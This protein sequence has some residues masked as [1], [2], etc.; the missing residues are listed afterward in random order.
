MVKE[1][2]LIE[3]GEY[4]RLKENLSTHDNEIASDTAPGTSILSTQHLLSTVKSKVGIMYH[5]KVERLFEFLKVHPSLL[6]W[7]DLV[8][9]LSM[10]FICQEVMFM[11]C[12]I[13]Y[14]TIGENFLNNPHPKVWT[15]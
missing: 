13:T 6:T 7:T 8:K 3:H 11:K 14:F 4:N 12:L 1:F 2:V 10:E 5:N 15:N 9:L